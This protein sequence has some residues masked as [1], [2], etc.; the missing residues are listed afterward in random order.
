MDKQEKERIFDR[1]YRADTS[2]ERSVEGTGLGL[3]IVRSIIDLHHGKI[4][5]ESQKGIGTTIKIVLPK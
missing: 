1:F 4:E 3:S 2:R 5:I